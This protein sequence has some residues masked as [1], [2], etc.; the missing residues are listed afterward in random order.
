MEVLPCLSRQLPLGGRSVPTLPVLTRHRAAYC[1]PEKGTTRAFAAAISDLIRVRS[2][3]FRHGLSVLDLLCSQSATV[4]WAVRDS[5]CSEI[6]VTSVAT[7]DNVT[8]AGGLPGH[9]LRLRGLTGS[10]DQSLICR[11]GRYST[12]FGWQG[13]REIVLCRPEW[14]RLRTLPRRPGLSLLE[15]AAVFLLTVQKRPK[16]ML[17]G[18]GMSGIGWSPVV[19]RHSQW[20]HSVFILSNRFI[21]QV[22]LG[23]TD[24]GRAY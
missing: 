7:Y 5:A 20:C 17:P 2:L 9:P 4:S 23:L 6:E 24:R 10:D 22:R 11:A 14:A 15:T 16:P 12:F 21:E 3:V 18:L 1:D 19:R 13:H 8:S